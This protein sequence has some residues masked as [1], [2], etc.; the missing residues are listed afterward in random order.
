MDID[1][2]ASIREV[3]DDMKAVSITGIGTIKLKHVSAFF[4]DNGTT[5][6]PPQMVLDINDSITPNNPLIKT[7]ANN[8]GL[9]KQEAGK[10]VSTFNKKLLTRLVNYKKVYL[11]GIAFIQYGDKGKVKVEPITKDLYNYYNGLP[12]VKVS[13]AIKFTKEITDKSIPSPSVT[14]TPIKKLTPAANNGVETK[15]YSTAAKSSITPPNPSNK[16]IKKDIPTTNVKSATPIEDVSKVKPTS[17]QSNGDSSLA[18]GA[19]NQTNPVYQYEE[20]KPS[21]L[22]PLILAVALILVAL[23]CYKACFHYALSGNKDGNAQTKMNI[24]K[25]DALDGVIATDSISAAALTKLRDSQGKLIPASGKCKII[26]GVFARNVNT[27]RMKDKVRNQGY[28]T[29][30]ESLGQYTRV[31]L[32]FNCNEETDLESFLQQVRREI[33]YRAW[34]LDPSLYVEYE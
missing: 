6:S 16:A 9:S 20:K 33:A 22:W 34:Y 4:S 27:L 24:Q 21:I 2:A 29:Y 31:G 25:V 11:K 14:A 10:V 32:I 30:T 15:D 17:L 13:S 12:K 26:T 23:L 7:I 18:A 8:Y 3:L 1:V 28:E 5:L 19:S